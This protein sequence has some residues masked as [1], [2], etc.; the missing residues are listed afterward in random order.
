MIMKLEVRTKSG[1]LVTILNGDFAYGQY[2]RLKKS[3][4]FNLTQKTFTDK[5]TF[6]CL[7]CI[8]YCKISYG[9][10]EMIFEPGDY[11]KIIL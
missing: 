1:N 2:V 5:G 4:F 6:D 9:E 11:I 10:I 8:D 7:L 3:K